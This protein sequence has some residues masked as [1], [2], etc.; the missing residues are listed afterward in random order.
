MN[1]RI[2][3]KDKLAGEIDERIYKRIDENLKLS[4]KYID[5]LKEKYFGPEEAKLEAE[6]LAA[7]IVGDSKTASLA[8][9]NAQK[10]EYMKLA[11]TESGA[12]E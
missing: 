12:N 6:T 1:D 8:Q 5:L 10:E 9:A 7:R 2:N 3:E 11:A 4:N